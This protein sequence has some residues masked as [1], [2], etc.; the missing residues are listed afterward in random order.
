M[1]SAKQYKLLFELAATLGPNFTATFKNASQVMSTMSND[2]KSV[3]AK[4]KDVSA[5]QKQQQAVDKSK[6]RVSQLESEHQKLIEE[7]NRTGQ[8]T[9]AMTAKLE[10]NERAM[11][12]ARDAAA[13]EQQKLQELGNTLREAG[14]NTDNLDRET[15]ELTAQYNRLEQAQN[16][17]NKI[18]AAQE[19]NKQAISQTKGELLGMVGVAAAVGG[20]IY[21]GPVKK[22]A[23]FE[24]QMSSVKAISGVTG[25]EL[26]ALSNKAKEMGASTA[27]T[28]TEAGEA[29]EYMAMA[30]WKTD[31][32]LGGLEGI[33]NLA[34]AAGADLGTT[35]DIVTDALTAFGLGAGDATHFADVLAQ[36]SSNANTDVEMM[37]ATFQKVAPVAGTLGYS[38]EDMSLG[39]GMMANAGVKAEVAGTSLKSALLNMA[40][41]TKA[42]AAAMKQYGISLTNADG[43]MKSFQDVIENMRSSLGGLSEQEQAAAA[44][45]I[46]GK[47]AVAGMLAIV[48]AGEQDFNKLTDAVYNCD[49]AAKQ[50]AE[51]KLDNLNGQI[52]LAKSAFDGLQVELGQMLLPA[53]TQGIEGLTGFIT[54]LTEFTRQNPGIVKAIAATGAGLFGL[55]AASLVGKL[56]FLEVKGGVLAAQKAITAIKGIGLPSFLSSITGGFAGI[57]PAVLPV[58][59]VIAAVG[60]AIYLIATHLEEVRGFIQKTFGDDA[61]AVFDK[62]W[63]GLSNIGATIRDAFTGG[64][65][66]VLPSITSAFSGLGD[67]VLNRVVPSLANLAKGV[68]PIIGNAISRILPVIQNI[69]SAVLPVAIQIIGGLISVIAQVIDKVLQIGSALIDTLA[70]AFMAIGEAIINFFVARFEMIGGVIQQVMPILQDLIANALPVLTNLINMVGGAL[71]VVAGFVANLLA[72]LANIAAQIMTALAPAFNF[73]SEIIGTAVVSAVQTFSN[74]CNDIM[75]ILNGVID[76]IT[77]VFTGNWGQAWEGVKQIFSGIVSGLDDIFKAPIR[78]IVAMINKVITGINGVQIPDW[79]PG[80]GGQKLNIPTIPEFAK[81]TNNTPDTFI[82]GEKGPE[83]IT[84]AAG[85]R[86]F[87]AGQTSEI[88][89]NATTGASTGAAGGGVNLTINVNNNPT[90]SGGNTAEVSGAIEQSNNDLVEKIRNAVLQ[91]MDEEKDRKGRTVYA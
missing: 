13:S 9:P 67:T 43:S 80:V 77:G 2:L 12:K 16:K 24:E 58:V 73:L 60:A 45:T 57:A 38:V 4:M 72:G 81:G 86:V 48:N 84:G 65:G 11:S 70:P 82:A 37:G 55:K 14:I 5:Y 62:F 50:M 3:N 91:I 59:G 64:L 8:A 69:I 32:M 42:Q 30:G 54:K 29:M 89:S 22:A 39:I 90:I 78:A 74:I 49:G 31:D 17:I 63:A 21:A 27:F 52:T 53:L 23:E 71:S 83:L 76:F 33:M 40:S 41:P 36:A 61:L 34:A 47:E 46:F 1:A 20:A 26:A 44:S 75:T 88:F 19:A 79:V 85:R 56:G 35:S 18:S 25:E 10:A 15:E 28:A 68:L 7:I 66:N 87:T 6:E 51:T